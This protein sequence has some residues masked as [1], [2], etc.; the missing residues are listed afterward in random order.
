VVPEGVCASLV[1]GRA[2]GVRELTVSSSGDL[3]AAAAN[4]SGGFL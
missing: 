2:G 1:L 3:Y 4:G